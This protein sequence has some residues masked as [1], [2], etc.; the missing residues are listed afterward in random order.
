MHLAARLWFIAFQWDALE[1]LAVL[2]RV[3]Q[4]DQPI[5]D[6]QAQGIDQ[7]DIVPAR[8]LGFGGDRGGRG[9]LLGLRLGDA[10]APALALVA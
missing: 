7:L 8:L 2:M 4:W 10:V 3:D 6:L 9:L 1:Q 5:A